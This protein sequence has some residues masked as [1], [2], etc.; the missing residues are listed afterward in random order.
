[1]PWYN[2]IKSTKT[3]RDRTRVEKHRLEN[4]FLT[5]C[6][7]C[8]A[9]GYTFKEFKKLIS[10]VLLRTAA[11][12]LSLQH[13]SKLVIA[14]NNYKGKTK[15]KPQS[16]KE[17]DYSRVQVKVKDHPALALVDLQTTG[18]DLINAQFVHL[19]GL[20]THGIDKKSLNPMIKG[21]KSV[22]EKACDVQMDYGGYTETR[23]L[24]VGHL[25]VWDMILANPAFTALN[26]LIPAGP[27]PVTI[28]SKGMV[29]FT[30][31][32]WKK[33]GP[34]TGQVTSAA[35]FM[36]D[37]VPEY[38]LPLFEFMVSANSL[39]ESR[40]FNPFVEFAQLFPATTPNELPPLKTINHRICL[41]PGSTRVPKWRPSPSKFYD[42]L[43]RQLT[44][45]EAS[46]QIYRAEHDTNAV[47]L[48]V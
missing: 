32:E 40:E 4:Q 38:L 30:L 33:A 41:K 46:R 37:E 16:T 17:L 15:G 7:W 18:G 12:V 1:V 24:Y 20:S 8:R 22:I 5:K 9:P 11:Q 23:T 29:P 44:E 48:F 13:T 39:R 10:K 47:V 28:Q 2:T 45:E 6:L 25:A 31:K 43:T 14:K 36:E 34:A 21:S 3:A 19:Y 27:K 35:L 42:E 26:V